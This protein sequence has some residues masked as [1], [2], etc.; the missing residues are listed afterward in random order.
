MSFIKDKMLRLAFFKRGGGASGGLYRVVGRI[1]IS[2]RKD[3]PRY[4]LG[5]L[6]SSRT[7]W[8]IPFF[9][10]FLLLSTFI[11]V[12]VFHSGILCPFCCS[13]LL[14]QPEPSPEAP[15]EKDT[16]WKS[17]PWK[18]STC[19]RFAF[20][21]LPAR[22]LTVRWCSLL[23]ALHLVLPHSSAWFQLCSWK[24]LLA[25]SSQPGSQPCTTQYPAQALE[26]LA[27]TQGFLT[28]HITGK[29]CHGFLFIVPESFLLLFVS[30]GFQKA[31]KLPRISLWVSWPN[32]QVKLLIFL[33]LGH[34]L[35]SV[36]PLWLS[37]LQRWVWLSSSMGL[38]LWC[39]GSHN[40][41]LNKSFSLWWWLC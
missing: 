21:L 30:Y 27:Q 6:F 19:Y 23:I 25:P 32:A 33:S 2:S 4:F 11:C 39:L 14:Y 16:V 13:R 1:K 36:E 24:D 26:N 38:A 5:F 17:K 15:C 3:L 10:L 41:G 22:L 18:V 35:C 7:M 8:T 28:G 29:I 31:S 20:S 37:F 34:L 12:S 9:S 40:A